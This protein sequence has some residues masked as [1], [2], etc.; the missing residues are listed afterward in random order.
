MNTAEAPV[1]VSIRQQIDAVQRHLKVAVRYGQQSGMSP[2]E[3]AL[4]VS[5]AEAAIRS[6]VYLEMH[7]DRI[8]EAVR[9]ARTA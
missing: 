6:L 5:H 2:S 3:V 1:R 9:A 4:S 8:I 7:R